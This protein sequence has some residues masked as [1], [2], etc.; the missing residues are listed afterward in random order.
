MY[1]FP[2]FSDVTIIKASGPESFLTLEISEIKFISVLDDS[3]I[4]TY[5]TVV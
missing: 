1:K 5:V 4:I 3:Y 2:T